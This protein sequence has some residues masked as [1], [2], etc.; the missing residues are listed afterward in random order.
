MLDW[1]KGRGQFTAE[2]LRQRAYSQIV[3]VFTFLYTL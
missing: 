1:F 3:A 2:L